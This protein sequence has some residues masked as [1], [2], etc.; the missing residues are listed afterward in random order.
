MQ[1]LAEICRLIARILLRL[2][3]R[4]ANIIHSPTTGKVLVL[5]NRE[6]RRVQSHIHAPARLFYAVSGD[7]SSSR[8]V[9][10][11]EAAS[12]TVLLSRGAGAETAQQIIYQ[13]S[14]GLGV[15]PEVILVDELDTSLHDLD[16]RSSPHSVEFDTTIADRP[17]HIEDLPVVISQERTPLKLARVLKFPR[18]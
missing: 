10:A 1:A 5:S 9:G 3:A 14:H 15:V 13:V 16:F 7:G 12:G 11:T 8:V 6:F 17:H 4:V 2:V 18:Q